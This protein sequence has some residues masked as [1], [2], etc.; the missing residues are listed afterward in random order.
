MVENTTIRIFSMII[1][2]K[3]K[4]EKKKKKIQDCVIKSRKY[5]FC[6]KFILIKKNLIFVKKITFPFLEEECAFL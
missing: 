6:K 2:R 5:F 4:I 1:I 3:I